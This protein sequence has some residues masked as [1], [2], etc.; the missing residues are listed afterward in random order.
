MV[1]TTSVTSVSTPNGEAA[2]PVDPSPLMAPKRQHLRMGRICGHGQ[3]TQYKHVS[4]KGKMDRYST[5]TFL[6]PDFMIGDG[7]RNGLANDCC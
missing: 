3:S 4:M 7:D 5:D 6:K 2:R 1:L